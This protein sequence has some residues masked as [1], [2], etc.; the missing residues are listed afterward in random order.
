VNFELSFAQQE[1]LH[2]MSASS[3]E[4][5]RRKPRK[6]DEEL[7]LIVAERY[8]KFKRPPTGDELTPYRATVARRFGGYNKACRL[9]AEKYLTEEERERFVWRCRYCDRI[10]FKSARG[11]ATHERSC[12]EKEIAERD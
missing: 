12:K 2:C 6:T 7:L 4:G 3:S 9:A 5:P 10:G 11:L 8:R 1:I